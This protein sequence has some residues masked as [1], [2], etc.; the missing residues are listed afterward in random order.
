MTVKIGTR[1]RRVRSEKNLNDL[2][3][4]QVQ[5]FLQKKMSMEEIKESKIFWGL[6]SFCGFGRGKEGIHMVDESTIQ[7]SFYVK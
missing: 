7:H 1:S 5:N 4:I 3:K 6:K 2:L